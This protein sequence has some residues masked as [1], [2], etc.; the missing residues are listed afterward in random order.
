M[1]FCIEKPH[2]LV[3]T[4]LSLELNVAIHVTWI[5]GELV[6]WLGLRGRLCFFPCIFCFS[7]AFFSYSP[8]SPCF[9]W[10]TSL[11]LLNYAYHCARISS[12]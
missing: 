10:Y 8:K 9:T 7:R 6:I 3:T 5:E 12:N 11:Y 2:F 1:V 4:L